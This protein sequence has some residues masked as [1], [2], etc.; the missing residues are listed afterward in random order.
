M[1]KADKQT[2]L[3]VIS[4]IEQKYT[5]VETLRDLA[6]SEENYLLIVREVDRVKDQLI[7]ARTLGATATLTVLE[8]FTIL[9]HFS[10][11]CAYCRTKPFQVLSHKISQARGGTTAENCVPACHSCIFRRRRNVQNRHLPYANAHSPIRQTTGSQDD[12]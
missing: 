6:G 5:R 7:R 11:Q 8:W 12:R 4:L 1:E 2:L 10:W 9:E 3:R